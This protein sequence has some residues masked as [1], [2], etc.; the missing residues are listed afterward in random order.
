MGLLFTKHLSEATLG[1][2]EITEPLHELVQDT[3]LTPEE[4]KAFQNLKA[5]QR[6]KQWLSYRHIIP[7]LK[8]HLNRSGILYDAYGKPYPKDRSAFLSVSHA[9]KFSAMIASKTKHV[10]IDIECMHPRIHKI[11]AKFLSENEKSWLG[12]DPGLE[13]LYLV[14]GAKESLYKLHGK[15]QLVF[16]EHLHTEPFV[17][18]GSGEFWGQILNAGKVTR[19]QLHYET[20]DDYI[21][22]Y[23]M[24]A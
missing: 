23:T 22:V 20:I 12:P 8:P 16:S 14:W 5:P 21:L 3:V 17:Y 13:S 24:S 1:V 18:S 9:G 15:G 7:H 10:G 19:Y 11:S 2:W 6:K 4:A